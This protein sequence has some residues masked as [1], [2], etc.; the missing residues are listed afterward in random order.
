[1][2]FFQLNPPLTGWV[3]SLHDEIHFVDEIRLDDGW[4]D[5][6]SSEVHRTRT[7]SEQSEDFIAA[8]CDFILMI[9]NGYAVDRSQI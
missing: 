9:Y 8:C 2:V 6:I 1:M 4:V 5:F 3:K 7:S